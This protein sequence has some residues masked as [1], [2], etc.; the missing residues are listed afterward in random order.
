[1]L[2]RTMLSA[3]LTTTAGTAFAADA[4]RPAP[5]A[6]APIVVAPMAAGDLSLGV[7]PIWFNDGP[8]ETAGALATSGRASM[9]LMNAWNFEAEANAR[10]YFFFDGGTFGEPVQADA[11]LHLWKRL[12]TSSWG[13][14]GGVS[15]FEEVIWSAGGEF[16]HYL[17]HASFAAAAAVT[18]ATFGPDSETGGT[19]NGTVNFYPSPD[20]RLGLNAT[21]VFG[22]PGQ[23]T[24]ATVTGEVEHRG[25]G[26]LSLWASAS[27][28]DS[29]FST[30]WMALGGFRIFLDRPGSTLQSHEQDVPFAFRLPDASPLLLRVSDVRL[31]RDIAL[32]GR[33]PN[34]LGLYRY[35]YLWSDTLYVGV[36]AQEVAAV[37]PRAVVEGPDGYLRV[38]YPLLGTDL[39]TWDQWRDADAE[40]HLETAVQAA[41]ARVLPSLS[42][43]L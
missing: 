4:P 22:F 1:M 14:F 13:V 32:V 18:M 7:G 17:P 39:M 28:T 10:D 26:P 19:V 35:R 33:L 25:A 20:F 38:N 2:L 30:Q 27:W 23:G 37:V 3:L 42:P 31:K 29:D 43:S 21:D 9:P 24:W 34:G 41:A 36:M 12:P 6:P 5:V 15:P 11:Y 40:R 16:K 8:T